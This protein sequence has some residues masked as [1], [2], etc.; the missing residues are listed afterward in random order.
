ML[1]RKSECRLNKL[2]TWSGGKCI[3]MEFSQFH[4]KE[5][6]ECEVIAPYKSEHNAISQWKNMSI[7]NMARSMLKEKK[8]LHR[9][10]GDVIST[11]LHITNINPT[12]KPMNK[13]PHESWTCRKP[14]VGHF[15]IF[16]SVCFRYVLVQIKKKK[17]TWWQKSSNGSHSTSAYKLYAPK[18]NN[19][20][21]S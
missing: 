10:W 5:G 6:M 14:S 18:D 19:V 13:T 20:V 11:S 8:M 17:K 2:R 16:G 15:K 21:I 12:K 1:R 3:S 7:I 4:E 9:F